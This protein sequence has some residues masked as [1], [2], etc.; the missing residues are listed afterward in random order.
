MWDGYHFDKLKGE[1]LLFS[2]HAT[3]T[4]DELLRN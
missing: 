2:K 1:A 3:K 4:M